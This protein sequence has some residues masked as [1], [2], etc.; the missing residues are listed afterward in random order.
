MKFPPDSSLANSLENEDQKLFLG[1]LILANLMI[2]EIA[3]SVAGKLIDRV[4][5]PQNFRS[6]FVH[7]RAEKIREFCEF[8]IGGSSSIALA[9]QK[10]FMGYSLITSSLANISLYYGFN[11][12]CNR[13]DNEFESNISRNRMLYFAMPLAGNF[14]KNTIYNSLVGFEEFKENPQQFN[15]SYSNFYYLMTLCSSIMAGI[16][17]MS[18]YS[19]NNQPE[20][21]IRGIL[22]Q[23]SLLN[24]LGRFFYGA[25][26]IEEELVSN[27]ES[28]NIGQSLQR[29]APPQLSAE[30]VFEEN[31]NTV[32]DPRNQTSLRESLSATQRNQRGSEIFMQRYLNQQMQEVLN[33]V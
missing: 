10:E 26:S 12:F 29:F 30:V 19:F 15:E 23:N 24:T 8:I 1:V 7:K 16:F 6:A 33:R 4:V 9:P 17:K 2:P 32:I 27:Q 14:V 31:P 20:E 13:E 21:L 22:R 3:S 18:L 25:N 5:D 28:L 11:N